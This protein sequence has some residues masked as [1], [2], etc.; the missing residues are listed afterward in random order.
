M[1]KLIDSMT[2]FFSVFLLCA[3]KQVEFVHCRG[4]IPVFCCF[5]I[6]LLFKIPYIFDFR[7]FWIDEKVEKEGVVQIGWLLRVVIGCLKRYERRVLIQAKQVVVLT[8]AAREVLLKNYNL[9]SD[10]VV[11][12]CCADF[13]VFSVAPRERTNQFRRTHNIPLDSFIIGYLGSIGRMYDMDRWVRFIQYASANK[14]VFAMIVSTDKKRAEEIIRLLG[15]Q[16]IPGM[17]LELCGQNLALAVGSMDLMVGFNLI[18]EARKGTSLT[19]LGESL[20]C[21]VPFI[22]SKGI[23]DSEIILK[24]TGGGCVIDQTHDTE[25]DR[26]W[27]I[28]ERFTSGE[29]LRNNAE[30]WLSVKLGVEKYLGVYGRMK[31]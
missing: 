19:K 17:V 28:Q 10:P 21:G 27:R 14:S 31:A 4:H 20:A 22:G 11:I 15:S 29:T 30:K 6:F 23:G 12:P 8:S 26:A 1:S 16:S 18:T 5:P 24:A 7:G 3:R 13:S 2:F 25:F 9:L